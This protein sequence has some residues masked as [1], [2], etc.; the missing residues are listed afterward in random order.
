MVTI[1][2]TQ[3]LRHDMIRQDKIDII[4]CWITK[5]KLEKRQ[6]KVWHLARKRLLEIFF[7]AATWI[8]FPSSA[9]ELNIFLDFFRNFFS[10]I[11]L[12]F[13]KKIFTIFG[14]KSSKLRRF[15]CIRKWTEDEDKDGSSD[16][17]FIVTLICII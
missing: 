17:S 9:V 12:Y 16:F 5:W 1:F 15:F 13:P 4:Y 2:K 11:L 8:N 3:T 6:K 10:K 7:Q 14:L